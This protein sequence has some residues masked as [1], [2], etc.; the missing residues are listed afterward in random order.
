M[1]EVDR[2]ILAFPEEVQSILKE[3]RHLIQI[4]SP[5]AVES[6]AYSIPAYKLNNKPLVYFAA[7]K[8]HIGF[9]ALPSGHLKFQDELSS[10]KQGKGSLQF[11]LN[12]PVP[13]L[14]IEK[15]IEFRVIEIQ[16][17]RI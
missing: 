17:K 3:I 11:P 8:N 4:T 16:N 9:Y 12:Q 13:Y 10:Y 2:Y 7:F 14:L 15:I 1:N 6:M 5:D